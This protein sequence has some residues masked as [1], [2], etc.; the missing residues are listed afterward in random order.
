M[1]TVGHMEMV[2]EQCMRSRSSW[3]GFSGT[4]GARNWG[5]IGLIDSE[6]TEDEEVAHSHSG[7]HWHACLAIGKC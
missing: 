4:A 5:T 1:G 6:E 3:F 7:W 2:K